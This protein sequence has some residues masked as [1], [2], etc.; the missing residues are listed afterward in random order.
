MAFWVRGA[1][2]FVGALLVSGGLPGATPAQ[3]DEP[4][5]PAPHRFVAPKLPQPKQWH[6]PMTQRSMLGGLWMTDPNYRSVLVLKNEVQT[7][8]LAVTPVLYLANGA[9]YRLPEVRL[10]PAGT[11]VV[12]LNAALAQVGIASWADLFGYV[13]VQYS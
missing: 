13:E 6:S 4:Y 5:V 11:A 9:K 7:S 10:E 3:G 2:C 1:V 8:A 12:D